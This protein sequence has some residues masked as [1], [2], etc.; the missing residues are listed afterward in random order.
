MTLTETQLKLMALKRERRFQDSTFQDEGVV[1]HS[2]CRALV[3]NDTLSWSILWQCLALMQYQV[4]YIK[5]H[6]GLCLY[7]LLLSPLIP[8][9]LR[10]VVHQSLVSVPGWSIFKT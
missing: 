7:L 8:P 2:W 4:L 1:G 9:H 3:Y 10:R 5:Q 6:L